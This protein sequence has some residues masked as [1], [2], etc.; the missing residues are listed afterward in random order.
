M[1]EH[2]DLKYSKQLGWLFKDS[3]W[4]WYKHKILGTHLNYKAIELLS[5]GYKRLYPAINVDMALSVLTKMCDEGHDMNFTIN[6]FDYE[7][8]EVK[9]FEVLFEDYSGEIWDNFTEKFYNKKLVNAL[10]KL[11]IWCVD[12]KY[13]RKGENE[14]KRA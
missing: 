9:E 2:A 5:D 8:Y 14:T 4:C 7:K 12:N 13:I 10:C 11:I 1:T 3:E 6:Y